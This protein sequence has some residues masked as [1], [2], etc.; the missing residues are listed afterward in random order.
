MTIWSDQSRETPNCDSGSQTQKDHLCSVGLPNT[1]FCSMEPHFLS[2]PDNIYN[3]DVTLCTFGPLMRYYKVCDRYRNTPEEI[4]LHN[5]DSLWITVSV[6]NINQHQSLCANK[7]QTS[8]AAAAKCRPRMWLVGGGWK[9]PACTFWPTERVCLKST[10][11]KIQ[12]LHRWGDF[13]THD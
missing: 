9:L 5:S 3:T 13:K 11:A 1:Q 4:R 12:I 10:E 8:P 7:G 2:S 6:G